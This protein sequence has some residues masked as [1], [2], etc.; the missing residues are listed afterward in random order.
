MNELKKLIQELER[1][2]FETR[3]KADI[4]AKMDRYA[5]ASE[6]EILARGVG[7]ALDRAKE[8]E[9]GLR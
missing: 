7:M 1:L 4:A 6:W 2:K 3:A 9:A 5:D 8:L